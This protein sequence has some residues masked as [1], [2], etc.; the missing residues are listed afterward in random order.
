MGI[1]LRQ[2]PAGISVAMTLGLV[3]SACAGSTA[4]TQ[5]EVGT[6]A[7]TGPL[8]EQ[9]AE[10]PQTTSTTATTVSSDPISSEPAETPATTDVVNNFPDATVT[11]VG[12]GEPFNLR[13]LADTGTPVAMWFYYPH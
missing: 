6:T 11:D 10:P 2:F 7:T 3:L 4:A 5:S 9:L 1:P 13:S 8:D 12:S